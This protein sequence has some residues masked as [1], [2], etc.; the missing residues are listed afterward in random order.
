MSSLAHRWAAL[1][2]GHD[3]LGAELLE[4]WSEPHRRYHDTSHL[5]HALDALVEVGGT[6]RPERLAIWFHDAVHTGT[7]GRDEHDSAA[8][9]SDRLAGTALDAGEIDEVCRLVLVTIEHSPAAGDAAGARVSDADLAI[10]AADP[11]RYLASV[12]ALRSELGS[13][14]DADW[15][16]A[17]LA[18]LAELLAAESLFHTP[19]GRHQWLARARTNLAAEQR[20]LLVPTP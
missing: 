6:A 17:R 4:R 5:S 2:P 14:A 11:A 10:L 15:R 3:A 7:P 20:A 18:R 1:L 16:E 9:A 8:L 12:D 13:V 19:T